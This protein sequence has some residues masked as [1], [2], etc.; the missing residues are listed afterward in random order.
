MTLANVQAKTVI[1]GYS[2][3]DETTITNAIATAYN[4]SPLFAAMVDNWLATAGNQLTFNFAANAANAAFNTGNVNLDLAYINTINYIDNN[5]NAVEFEPVHVIVHELGHAIGG[6]RD[7][8]D[9]VMDWQGDTLRQTNPMLAELG[10]PERNAYRG[11][12][13]ETVIP[14]GTDYTNGA[15]IDRSAVINGS[16]NSSAAGNSIDLLIGTSASNTLETGQGNDF[17]FGGGGDDI[18]NGGMG[19]TDTVVLSGKPVDYDI[20]LNADG[21]WTSKHVRGSADE[22]TDTFQNLEQVSFLD[23]DDTFNL[24]KSGLTYQTDIAFVVD[25]TGSMADD[26]AAVQAAASGVISA[27]FADNTIDAR[28]GVVGFRDNT[29][30]EPTTVVLP[31]TDQDAFADRQTA[32]VNAIASL[33]ASGGGD[34]PETAFDGLLQA[35]DGTMGEWRIGAGTKK[36]ALFTDATAKDAFLA[37]TVLAFATNIGATISSSSTTAL[38]EIGAVDTFELSFAGPDN[39]LFPGSE[40]DPDPVFNPSGDPIEAPVGSAVVQVTTIFIDTFTTG[41]PSFDALSAATGGSVLTA[42]DPAEVVDRLLEVVTAANYFMSVDTS[43]L[44]EGDAGSTTVTFTISRDRTANAATVTLAATGHADAAD[45][46][47]VP[48]TLDFAVGEGSKTV[49]VDI[50]GDTLFEPDETFGLQITNVDE[51][52]QLRR[53]RCRSDDPER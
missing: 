40:G 41:D 28:V 29:I 48:T 49:T 20:R 24:T 33:G 44:T 5:G 12:Q 14:T 9:D 42:A 4:G 31:F 1:N 30:G 25:Q 19:G 39:G 27:L 8:I 11:A 10:I 35:L 32:A 38:G 50:L 18:L 22:G 13:L 3:A 6:T 53:R 47:S 34:F 52:C 21:T 17:L 36:V 16:F 51:L 45:V 15:A 2:A 23:G 26:I 7:N 37:P 43:S 46:A